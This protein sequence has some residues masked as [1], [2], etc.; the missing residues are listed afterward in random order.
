[1]ISQTGLDWMG[2]AS[3]FRTQER[4]ITV[5]LRRKQQPERCDQVRC[6]PESTHG[7]V[8]RFARCGRSFPNARCE[9]CVLASRNWATI[10]RQHGLYLAT[11]AIALCGFHLN[12]GL[13][14]VRSNYKWMSP[15]H[16]FGRSLHWCSSTILSY[17][18]ALLQNIAIMDTIY[19]HFFAAPE[20]RRSWRKIITLPR[21]SINWATLFAKGA[22]RL[23]RTQ[24]ILSKD[25]RPD[26]MLPNWNR[27][28]PS[29]MDSNGL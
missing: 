9:E 2:S 8:Y 24:S 5:I 16:R 1:M 27:F 15:F 25:S 12:Y 11:D 19:N 20:M 3:S 18:F 26:E 22:W 6:V 7:R 13:L 17:S 10:S 23:R 29:L 28:W 21:Q 4:R 14:S